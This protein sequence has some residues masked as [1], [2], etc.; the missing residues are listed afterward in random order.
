MM[1]KLKIIHAGTFA[2]IQD[3]GRST[4]SKY[5]VPKSGFIDKKSAQKMN[6][7]LGNK[8]NAACL[9][10]TQIGPILQFT[11]ATQIVISDTTNKTTLNGEVLR[12]NEIIDVPKDTLLNLGNNPNVVYSYLGIKDGFQT[13]RILKS[14]SMQ[15]GVTKSAQLN[16]KSNLRYKAQQLKI[17]F[18]KKP[19][20]GLHQPFVD[21][22]ARTCDCFP[23]P[24]Y[25]LLSEEEQSSL[26]QYF[27]LSN[28]RNRMGMQLNELL[29]NALPSMLSVPIL[30]GTVQLTPSGKLIVLSK[31]CQTTG[32]YPRILHL[33]E[34]SLAQLSQTSQN[35]RFRFNILDY[36]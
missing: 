13:S 20:F 30:P 29:P 36:N 33:P 2:S 24:E 21:S 22:L 35:V 6:K 4:Y 19:T 26:E 15:K 8:K 1:A 16:P 28:Q 25:E 11:S 23:G 34:K 32:G 10:W 31:D 18:F 27:T 17:C 9:E 12:A 7:I 5:G 14:R 3:K